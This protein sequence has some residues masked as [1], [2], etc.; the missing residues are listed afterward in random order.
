MDNSESLF[1]DVVRQLDNGGVLQDM[2]LIGSWALPVYRTH[3]GNDPEVPILRTTD[4]DFLL[5]AP[6][7]VRKQLDVPRALAS[8]GFDPDWSAHGGYCRY[9]H[10]EMEVEFLIPNR[11]KGVDRAIVVENLKVPAQPLR[12]VSLAY[13]CSIVVSFRGHNIRVPEPEAFTLLKLLVIPRR[14]SPAKKRK[15]IETA[16]SLGDFLLSRHVC[17]TR[18]IEIHQ[19][20]PVSG[21]KTILREAEMHVPKL[22]QVLWDS[23]HSI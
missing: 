7:S 22:A 23:Q 16:R 1:L 21:R 20:L 17:A 12:F 4:I 9:V 19:T 14:K 18:I 5:G 15:D 10:P 11:G 13:D 6:P 8:I 3:F 2:V